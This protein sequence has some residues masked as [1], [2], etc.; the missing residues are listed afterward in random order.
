VQGTRTS[1]AAA[2][3]QLDLA[4]PLRLGG[5]GEQVREHLPQPAAVSFDGRQLSGMEDAR[6]PGKALPRH[7]RR[8]RGRRGGRS[9][10]DDGA[11]AGDFEEAA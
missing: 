8:P 1:L 9:A 3:G 6:A 4:V 2:P 11:I 5:V 7:A 10:G